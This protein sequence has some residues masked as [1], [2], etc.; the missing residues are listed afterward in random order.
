[1]HEGNFILYDWLSFTVKTEDP[2]WVID[3]ILGLGHVPWQTVKGA[4]GYRDRMYFNCIS[5]HYNGREDMGVWVELSGQGCRAFETLSDL[6]DKWE[7]LFQLIE[8]YRMHLTRLDVAYDDHT[9]I[10][11][12]NKI[13][14]DTR[15]QEYVSKSDYWE[16]IESSKGQSC[17]YGSPKSNTLIRIYDK[18]RERHCPEGEHW[19]R[20]ELQLRDDRA[21]SF[22]KLHLPIGQAYYGVVMNYLRFVDPDELDSNRWRWP[23][24]KYWAKFLHNAERISIYQSPGLDYNLD[25]CKKFVFHQAGNAIDAYIKIMGKDDFFQHLENRPVR[26][27]PKYENLVKEHEANKGK[28]PDTVPEPSKSDFMEELRGFEEDRIKSVFKV[29]YPSATIDR[30]NRRWVKCKVCGEI[31]RDF[32]MFEYG[33]K[34][35]FNLGTCLDCGNFEFP[36]P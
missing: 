15:K 6:P 7:T 25:R 13:I 36:S 18:A 12:I 4:R 23:I 28:I 31:K 35:G 16:I 30:F 29:D 24:K 26:P 9:G 33:G 10:L 3:D 1:M 14:Q 27:N 19:I 32:Q 5:V 34:D 2:L 11:D 8:S 20:C 21:A 17:Q 22:V